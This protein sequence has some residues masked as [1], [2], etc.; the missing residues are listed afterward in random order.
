MEKPEENTE[1][2]EET[3]ETTKK[4]VK[5][6]GISSQINLGGGTPAHHQWARILLSSGHSSPSACM[7]MLMDNY[8]NPPKDS[9][10]AA[11][12]INLEKQVGELTDT[13]KA[14]DQKIAELEKQLE[15]ANNMAND[16]AVNGLG[17][18]AQIEEL[19]KQMEGAII[20]KLNPVY[21][22]FMDEIV[23]ESG[24]KPDEILRK[25]FIG[26][27]QN[28]LANHLPNNYSVSGS[29]VRQVMKQ[30]EANQNQ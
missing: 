26:D 29:R 1:K 6:D 15:A 19:K 11:T 20:V 21:K 30:L 18:Q 10:S 28:P 2:K 24:M 16:N 8:E 27:I 5:I 3:A 23:K 13:N 4:S 9:D 7:K 17:K 25:I 12:I 14:K 22:Y